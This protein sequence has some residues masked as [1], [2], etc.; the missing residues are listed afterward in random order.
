MT[1]EG[2]SGSSKEEKGKEKSSFALACLI[3][4]DEGSGGESVFSVGGTAA[5]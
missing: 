1:Q 3:T 2:K 5:V 4:G